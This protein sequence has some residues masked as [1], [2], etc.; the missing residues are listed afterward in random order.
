MA[1][2]PF[3]GSVIS[4]GASLIGGKM[5]ADASNKAARLNA[6][7]QANEAAIARDYN[8]RM[9]NETYARN[10]ADYLFDVERE[11]ALQKEFAQQ[12]IRWRV[13]DAKAAGIHPLA[14]L[15]AQTFSYSPQSVGGGAATA[16]TMPRY[17]PAPYAGASGWAGLAQAGQDISRGI[18]A[19]HDAQQ[20][21]E[22][23]Q[24]TMMQMSQQKMGLENLLLASQIARVNAPGAPRLFPGSAA[25]KNGQADGPH[26]IKV[27]PMEIETRAPGNPVIEPAPI[28]DVGHLHSRNTP[29]GSYT[30]VPSKIAKERIE[31][32]FFLQLDHLVRNRLLPILGSNFN[33]PNVPLQKNK[34]WG[35]HPFRGYEQWHVPPT[36]GQNP[37]WNKGGSSASP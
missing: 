22:A 11:T 1:I 6:I 34:R 24:T 13:D 35:Y 29:S 4:A 9:V 23:Y 28:S 12:G 16:P 19:S 37:S 8:E 26:A 15:G 14:A 20:R 31:D 17:S 2:D 10:R 30:P 7:A 36:R 25:P 18:T 21:A 3:F 32:D 27:S 5:A 33:P